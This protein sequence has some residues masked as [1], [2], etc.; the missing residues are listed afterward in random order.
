MRDP[1]LKKR[2]GEALPGRGRLYC[3]AHTVCCYRRT[4]TPARSREHERTLAW[5]SLQ[6]SPRAA[7]GTTSAWLARRQRAEKGLMPPTYKMPRRCWTSRHRLSRLRQPRSNRRP[8]ALAIRHRGCQGGTQPDAG[9]PTKTSDRPLRIGRSRLV[10]LLT[11]IL[12]AMRLNKAVETTRV[13]T[14]AGAP[15]HLFL[16]GL[17]EVRRHVL[18]LLRQSRDDGVT[19]IPSPARH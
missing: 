9:V 18:E 17:P 10:C 11:T 13:H 4:S 7:S 12:P 16:D 6:A 2:A 1:A 3:C 14:V 5:W 8:M 15:R 19:N